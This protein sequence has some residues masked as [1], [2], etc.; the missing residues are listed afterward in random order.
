MTT[1]LYFDFNEFRCDALSEMFQPVGIDFISFDQSQH[2]PFSYLIELSPNV[3][4]MNLEEIEKI[5]LN[6]LKSFFLNLRKYKSENDIKYFL[7]MK[8]EKMND[9]L[10]E[11]KD[12]FDKYIEMPFE[13]IEVRKVTLEFLNEK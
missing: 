3:F 2:D 9:F 12:L 11:N 6:N 13:P 8:K 1:I 5:S 10:N 4:F 7:F